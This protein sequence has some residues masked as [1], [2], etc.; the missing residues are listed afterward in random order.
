[1]SLQVG[2][3]GSCEQATIE[4]KKTKLCAQPVRNFASGQVPDS[5]IAEVSETVQRYVYF[6]DQRL[7]TLLAMWI[8]GTYVVSIFSH[9]GYVFLH[10]TVPRCGK[11]R[12][13]EVTSHLAFE[14]T[15]PINAPTSAALREIAVEGGTAIFDTLERWRQKSAESFAAVM[16]IL[17]AGF[18]RGGL[19]KKMVSHKKN[20]W[21]LEEFPVY[22]PYMFAAIDRESLTDTAL[23]RSFAVPMVRKKIRVRTQQYDDSRCEAECAPIREKLYLMALTKANRIADVYGSA[24]LEG[25]IDELGITDRANDIWRPLFALAQALGEERVDIDL[26]SLAQDMSLD[27]D[28][29]EEQRQRAILAGLRSVVGPAGELAATTEQIAEMLRTVAGVEC[30]NLHGFLTEWGFHEKSYAAQGD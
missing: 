15:S 21:K 11:T 30:E 27:P 3:D 13:E 10:S 9:Y 8:A 23:D 20:D 17:D 14:A 19:A 12:V 6:S 1:M 16:E 28:H 5:P 4:G 24:A 29:H 26:R 22:A 25:C 18:R 7:Y 2:S